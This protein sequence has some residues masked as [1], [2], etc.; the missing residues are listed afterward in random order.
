VGRSFLRVGRLG[1]DG[2]LLFCF[3]HGNRASRLRDDFIIGPRP[4]L[5]YDTHHKGAGLLKAVSSFQFRVSSSQQLGTADLSPPKEGAE[6]VLNAKV[7]RLKPARV[8]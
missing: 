3:G 6:K 5:G 8:I 7:R 1:S 4:E 2:G